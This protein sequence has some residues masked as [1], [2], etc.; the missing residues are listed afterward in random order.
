MASDNFRINDL[1]KSV[2]ISEITGEKKSVMFGKEGYA[3]NELR[4]TVDVVSNRR[5]NMYQQLPPV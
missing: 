2:L 1:I 4:N 3:A 5:T